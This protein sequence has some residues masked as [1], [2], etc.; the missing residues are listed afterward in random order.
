VLKNITDCGFFGSEY[1]FISL[2]VSRHAT[3]FISADKVYPQTPNNIY[4]L[5]HA[6]I[7]QI[8]TLMNAVLTPIAHSHVQRPRA[9][10]FPNPAITLKLMSAER[11]ALGPLVITLLQKNLHKIA[12]II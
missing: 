10:N 1:C 3:V 9:P 7:A 5:E 2:M 12:G 11:Q 8:P 6:G 4:K